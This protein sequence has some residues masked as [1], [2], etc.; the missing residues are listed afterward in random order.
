MMEGWKVIRTRASCT[1]RSSAVPKGFVN[2]PPSRYDVPARRAR[3][4]E[5]LENRPTL[6]RGGGGFGGRIN[7]PALGAARAPAS[8]NTPRKHG[9]ISVELVAHQKNRQRQPQTAD[10]ASGLVDINAGKTPVLVRNPHA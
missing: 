8:A 7:H 9:Q 5:T 1:G 2:A 4:K 10:A 3:A 6:P